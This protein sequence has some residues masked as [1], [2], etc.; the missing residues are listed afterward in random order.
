MAAAV[1]TAPA[2][3]PFPKRLKVWLYTA[4]AAASSP[5]KKFPR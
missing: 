3:R 2:A 1:E 4:P 5:P